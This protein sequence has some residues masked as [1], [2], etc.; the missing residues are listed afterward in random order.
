[1]RR[2]LLTLFGIT[3]AVSCSISALQLLHT[4]F[5]ETLY[6]KDFTQFYLMGHA[7]R[8][9]ANLYAP[10]HD[11]ATQFDPHLTDWIKISAYP[12]IVAVIGLPFSYLPY[13]WSVIIWMVFELG[14]LVAAVVLIVRYFGGRSAPTP[15]LVTACAFI[16]W[17]PVFIDLYHGQVMIPILLLLT[18]VWLALKAGKDVK[19][20]ILLGIVI[21]I[22]LYAWPLAIFLLLKRRWRAPVTAFAVF[23]AATTLMIALV[24]SATIVDYYSRVG[25]AVLEE[26]K[27]YPLNFSAWCIGLRSFGLVGAVTM[28][29]SVLLWSLFLALRSKDFDSSFMILLAGATV[30]QPISW[31]HY[32]VTLLPAFC[33]VA[34]RREFRTSDLVL[35]L[36]L[37]ALILPGFHH[38]SLNYP[39]ISPWPPFLFIIGLMWLIVPKAVL[40]RAPQFQNSLTPERQY[41]G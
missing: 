21:S 34:A 38:I 4:L 26:Y 36:F 12:P 9:G 23:I 28:F 20:G 17:Q 6:K 16:G 41:E 19:A 40:E 39:A 33:L 2:K 25:R 14:C 22:K 35:G 18:M 27:F 15:V 37:I 13:F 31:I 30:L 29:V 7:L 1:M 24:G 8:G 11:L 10:L 32:M 3:T 5:S